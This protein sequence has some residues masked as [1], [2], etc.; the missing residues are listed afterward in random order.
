MKF[1]IDRASTL[2]ENKKPCDRA[3]EL[4]GG[5]YGIKID[6]L[7]DLMNLVKTVE[8]PVIIFD[9]DD[10]NP[11]PLIWIYDDFIE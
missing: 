7:E 2:Y 1:L 4:A 5:G 6:N 9:A 10:G 3:I 8:H 11:L